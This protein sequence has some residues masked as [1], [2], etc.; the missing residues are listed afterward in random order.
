MEGIVAEF[1]EGIM[2]GEGRAYGGLTVFPLHHPQKPRPLCVT[3]DEALH[4]GT[5]EV[6]EVSE[7]GSVPELLVAN[8]GERPVL[9]LDGE[10]VVGARQNRVL[11]TSVLVAA[12]AELKIPVSSTEAGRWSCRSERFSASPYVMPRSCRREKNL[13]VHGSLEARMGFRSDQDG[14]WDSV[15]M[16]SADLGTGSRTEA[17]R[18]IFDGRRAELEDFVRSL[19]PVPGQKG[20][21]VFLG[22][23]PAGLDMLSRLGAY[24]ALHPKL[25]RGYAVEALVLRNG[26]GGRKPGIKQARAFLKDLK[27]CSESVFKSTG[28]GPDHRFRSP[29]ALGTALVWRK[30]VIHAA[31][32]R[33]DEEAVGNGGWGPGRM[34]DFRS[35]RGF[36]VY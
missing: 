9:V 8:G 22:G 31:F 23:E 13:S 2:V 36:I 25:L 15:R 17:M 28:L 3:L 21:L 24:S 12:G 7:E 4:R 20:L 5:L 1:L 34:G 6:R 32:F 19:K 29:R 33:A 11:N 26:A 18:E 27:G 35:R 10:E 30:R 14:V 16:M